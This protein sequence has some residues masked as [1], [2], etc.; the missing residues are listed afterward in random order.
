METILKDRKINIALF[1]FLIAISLFVITKLISEINKTSLSISDNTIVVS[2]SGEVTAVSDIASITV[3]L[4][5]DGET[6]KEAQNL[7]NEEISKTL[8]YLKGQNIEDKDIKSEYGGL[9]PKYSYDRNTKIS[10]IIGY[11]ADQS[12]TVKIRDIDNAN[13]VR[14][15]LADIGITDIE[16]PTFSIDDEEGLKDQARLEAIDEAKAKAKILA[17]ELGVKLGKIISYSDTDDNTYVRYAKVIA[18][19]DSQSVAAEGISSIL[20]VGESKVTSNITI[21]YEIR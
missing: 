16:G 12:I 14:T 1:I 17:K 9:T 3:N 11:T 18:T 4:T 8:E 2:G 13:N 5:K 21:I 6:S 15:G 19:Y 10:K 20:P 7:L